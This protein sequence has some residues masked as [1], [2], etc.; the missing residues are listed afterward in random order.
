M[1]ARSVVA[2]GLLNSSV[3]SVPSVVSTVLLVV[4]LSSVVSGSGT[5]VGSAR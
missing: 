2:S 3:A 5:A 4:A 1:E